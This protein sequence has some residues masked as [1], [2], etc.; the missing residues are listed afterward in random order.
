MKSPFPLFAALC[1]LLTSPLEGQ[2]PDANDASQQ[3]I[4]VGTGAS[5]EAASNNP[6][7][8]TN[9]PSSDDL[10]AT[11]VSVT[12]ALSSNPPTPPEGLNAG[13]NS[14]TNLPSLPAPDLPTAPLITNPITPESLP[15]PLPE[16]TTGP[17]PL[18]TPT[19]NNFGLIDKVMKL[20]KDVPLTAEALA[21]AGNKI[22]PSIIAKDAKRMNVDEVVQYALAHNP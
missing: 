14:F 3:G 16:T 2:Q 21:K 11:G 18:P 8:T 12:P 4:S 20:L 1:A 9:T 6:V 7:I 17:I 22:V 15:A 5:L 13:T 19:T 10:S